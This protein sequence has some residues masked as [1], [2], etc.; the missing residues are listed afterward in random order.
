MPVVRASLPEAE[1]GVYT[2]LT[3]IHQHTLSQL[4]IG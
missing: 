2:C 4:D 3:P 1:L